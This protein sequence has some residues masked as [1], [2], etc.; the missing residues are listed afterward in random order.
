M[1]IGAE[2]V[3]PQKRDLVGIIYLNKAPANANGRAVKVEAT[4]ILIAI[5]VNTQL[6]RIDVQRSLK[7]EQREGEIGTLIFEG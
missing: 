2:V 6:H 7:P 5:D 4:D 1:P 3:F